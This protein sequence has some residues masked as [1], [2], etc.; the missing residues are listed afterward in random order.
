[1]VNLFFIQVKFQSFLEILETFE[2]TVFLTVFKTTVIKTYISKISKND[3]NL[4]CKETKLT[5]FYMPD[6]MELFL[7]FYL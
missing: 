6:S 5:I 7:F 2:K 4:T 1:M 3:R